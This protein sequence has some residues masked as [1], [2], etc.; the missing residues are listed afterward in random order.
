M[1]EHSSQGIEAQL[2]ALRQLFR[3]RLDE[4]L[5]EIEDRAQAIESGDSRIETMQ[6]LQHSLHKLAGS[7]GTFGYE[8]LGRSARELEIRVASFLKSGCVNLDQARAFCQDVRRLR[9]EAAARDAGDHREVSDR[10]SEA[11][12]AGAPD[13]NRLICLVEDDQELADELVRTV[14]HFGYRIQRYERLSDAAEAMVRIT[15]DVLI[16]DV[17]FH[18]NGLNTIEEV[19]L[20]PVFQEGNIPI[21][22]LSDQDDFQTRVQAARIGAD[23]FFLKPLDIPSLIDRLEQSLQHKHAPP[24]RLL[25]V[26]DDENLGRR[27]ELVLR[28]AGMET[29]SVSRPEQALDA[30]TE[31]H[32]EMVLMDLAMPECSGMD[33]ARVI[34]MHDE[35]L[36]L[37]IV[38]LS[39]ETDQDKQLLAMSEGGDDFLTKPITDRHLVAAVSVRA[40]RMRQLSELMTRDS[41]TG[42]LKHSRIKEQITQEHARAK[43]TGRPL[44]V[45]MLDIDHFKKVN[46]THGH[47]MGDQVIKALAHLLKQ[48]L[49]K[50]DSIGRYGGEEFAAALPDCDLHAA[51]ILLEDIRTRFKEIRFS[52]GSE[53]FSVTLSAGAALAEHFD[54]AADMMAAADDALYEAKRGGRDQVR[55]EGPHGDQRK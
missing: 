18:D 35:W 16:M 7:A 34:R 32:P 43:R 21:I 44:C 14:G 19:A 10:K 26:D 30:L 38:F 15:P 50:T 6:A 53:T 55:I 54:N 9:H 24:Y 13:D 11:G 37:P 31:F 27:Y 39:A 42:L 8:A 41:L 46:D 23:G 49:R 28:Q 4:E 48:R 45:A 25:I 22:F 29:R 12:S 17:V 52:V 20:H 5:P 1:P 3:K 2:Q 33:L 51:R 47:A 40:A 36:S